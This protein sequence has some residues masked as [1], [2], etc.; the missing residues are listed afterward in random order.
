MVYATR[1]SCR[2]HLAR[3]QHETLFGFNSVNKRRQALEVERM[4]IKK[5]RIGRYAEGRFLKAKMTLKHGFVTLRCGNFFHLLTLHENAVNAAPDCGN[6]YPF[7]CP[8]NGNTIEN[9]CATE[10]ICLAEDV[11]GTTHKFSA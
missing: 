2:F 4:A 8:T 7:S 1:S 5:S 3:D 11:R 6:F 9:C 10:T